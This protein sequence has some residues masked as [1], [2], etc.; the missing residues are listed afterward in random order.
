MTIL[1]RMKDSIYSDR[2][3]HLDWHFKVVGQGTYRAGY[4]ILMQADP[5]PC[6]KAYENCHFSRLSHQTDCFLHGQLSPT[7]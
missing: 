3:A 6:D 4:R 5:V 2:L 7:I 1:P